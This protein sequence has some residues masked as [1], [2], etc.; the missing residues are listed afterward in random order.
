[1]KKYVGTL[2]AGITL[3]AGLPLTA[4]AA[5]TD[6]QS[7]KAQ[8]ELSQDTDPDKNTVT[9]DKAPGVDFGSQTIDNATTTYNADSVSGNIQVTNPGNTDGWAVSVAGT[10]FTDSSTS[11]TLKG[12]VLSFK[13]ADVSADDEANVST[14]P[15]SSQVDVN[16][17]NQQILGANADEGI[18]VFTAAY[19][20]ENVQLLVPA[21]N[22]AGSYAATLTWTLGN[23]PS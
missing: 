3:V 1:M 22:S 6:T 21:G 17:S 5:D 7:T 15:S 19:A 8:V 13:S 23:A 16:S 9:L 12:A 18:G 20:K 2:I 4:M 10:D 11:K 14:H